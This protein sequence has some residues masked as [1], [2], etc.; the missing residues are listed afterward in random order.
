MSRDWDERGEQSPAQGSRS[1]KQC[2]FTLAQD[3]KNIN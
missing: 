3:I 2:G 1:R